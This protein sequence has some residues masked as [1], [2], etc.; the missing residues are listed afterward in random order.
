MN[1][2][3]PVVPPGIRWR[4]MTVPRKSDASVRVSPVPEKGD[5]LLMIPPAGLMKSP[6]PALLPE[7]LMNTYFVAVVPWTKLTDTGPNEPADSMYVL[8]GELSAK[9]AE[10]PGA[11]VVAEPFTLQFVTEVFH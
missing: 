4:K 7:L 5:T 2:L 10:S 11:Q 3:A 1:I 9:T 8:V 6:V